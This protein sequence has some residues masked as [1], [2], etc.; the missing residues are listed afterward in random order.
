MSLPLQPLPGGAPP[1]DCGL[2]G[3]GRV[4]GQGHTHPQP[5]RRLRVPSTHQCP[6]QP[7]HPS[8]R[9]SDSGRN[10]REK[11][12]GCNH[13]MPKK[14]RPKG[15]STEQIT[16]GSSCP[17]VPP[18]R[19]CLGL[20]PAGTAAGG[21]REGSA[22]ACGARVHVGS[23]PAPAHESSPVQ[24]RP[25]KQLRTSANSHSAGDVGGCCPPRTPTHPAPCWVPGCPPRS[26][27]HPAPA[28]AGREPRPVSAV[29]RT[30]WTPVPGTHCPARPLCACLSPSHCAPPP[31]RRRGSLPQENLGRASGQMAAPGLGQ[32]G[33][34][35]SGS[36]SSAWP[37]P[38]LGEGPKSP[39]L[40]SLRVCLMSIPEMPTACQPLGT[41]VA[42]S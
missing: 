9:V 39:C 4:L 25:V 6:G 42:G 34:G 29:S 15:A 12:R 18:A 1:S 23:A 19:V 17:S 32:T 36:W 38:G 26:L 41:Q 2:L 31:I 10:A 3:G 27:P 40:G 7:A 11:I 13:P 21:R 14:Q 35:G 28:P 5:P 24:T 30:L 37:K 8:P 16:L 33:A 22:L 20:P